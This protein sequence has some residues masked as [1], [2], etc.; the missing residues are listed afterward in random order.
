MARNDGVHR[1]T[2]RNVNLTTAKAQNAQHHNER[3]KESYSSFREMPSDFLLFF[4]LLSQAK[5]PQTRV[6]HNQS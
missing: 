4:R 6:F 3:Q 2:V 5:I 1:T